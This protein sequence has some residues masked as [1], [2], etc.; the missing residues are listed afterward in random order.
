[1]YKYEIMYSQLERLRFQY[2]QL[3]E[4]MMA[5]IEIKKARKIRACS[6]R[7]VSYKNK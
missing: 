4:Q 2:F 1:M 7:S 6:I 5:N 3:T